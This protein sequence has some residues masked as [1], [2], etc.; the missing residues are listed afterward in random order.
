MPQAIP[1]LVPE[2][3]SAE[4]VLPFLRRI[5]STRIYSNYGPLWREF[6]DGLA[7]YVA[8]NSHQNDI[9][10]S[11]TSSGTIALELALRAKAVR[12]ARYCLLPAYTFIATAHAVTNAHLEPF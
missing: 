6:T 1:I 12:K 10:V 3:P 11:L 5:D 8:G 9:C 4:D 7:T 2:L